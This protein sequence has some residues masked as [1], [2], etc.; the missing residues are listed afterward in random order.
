MGGTGRVGSSGAIP[1][2]DA[3]AALPTMGIETGPGS[4]MGIDGLRGMSPR[5]SGGVPVAC[6]LG[7]GKTSSGIPSTVGV[8]WSNGGLCVGK[9]E[10]GRWKLPGVGFVG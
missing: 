6:R 2:P 4:G 7:S 10:A 9:R 5:P 8:R 1:L 3:G